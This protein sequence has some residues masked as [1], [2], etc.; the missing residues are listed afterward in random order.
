MKDLRAPREYR[1]YRASKEIQETKGILVIPVR[2]DLR[3]PKE[4][5]EPV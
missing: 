2:L 4:I 3:D 5:P 1:E